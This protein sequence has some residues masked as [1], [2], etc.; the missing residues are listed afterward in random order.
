MRVQTAAR[1]AAYGAGAAALG[2][3]FLIGVLFSQAA[4]ARRTIPR[5]EAPP[6]RSEGRYGHGTASAPVRLVVLGDSSAAG[7]GVA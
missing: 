7:Y 3:G 6:P 2:S 4:L 1:A 5:A